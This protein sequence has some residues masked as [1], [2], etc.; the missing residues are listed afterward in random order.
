M[1][2]LEPKTAAISIGS[3]QSLKCYICHTDDN[4]LC[5]NELQDC[6]GDQAY[7]RCMTTIL[8]K[9][10]HFVTENISIFLSQF[11]LYE[12]CQQRQVA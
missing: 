8:K 9:R 2:F 10:K 12:T 11:Y 6:P 4:N 7:D 3:V 1:L 5:T